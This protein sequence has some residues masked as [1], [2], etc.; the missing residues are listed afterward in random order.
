MPRS[1]SPPADPEGARASGGS[2]REQLVR[3]IGP[4][5]HALRQRYGLSL[6]QLA[7]A[8][9]VSA[10]AV[11]KVERGEMVPTITTLLKLAQALQTPIRHFVEDDAEPR[12]LAVHSRALEPEPSSAG[13]TTISGPPGRFR[14]LSTVTRLA[15]GAEG[16]GP[17]QPGETLVVVVDGRLTVTVGEE[18]YTVDRG[19]S[20]HFPTDMEYRWANPGPGIAQAIWFSVA[21]G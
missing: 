18:Q 7:Q 14:A 6:Q 11:H 2:P 20:L 19:E 21:D 5:V 15:P 4:K 13:T 12:P 10:A 8:A 3:S 9:D 1:A 17:R 16:A